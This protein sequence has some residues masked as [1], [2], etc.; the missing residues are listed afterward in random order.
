MISV[1]AS[2]KR[3]VKP[4][5]QTGRG[6]VDVRWSLVDSSPGMRVL[7][8]DGESVMCRPPAGHELRDVFADSGS[9][10]EAVARA[11][12]GNPHVLQCRMAIDQ[13]VPRGRV[14]VLAHAALDERGVGEH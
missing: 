11:A 6:M 2:V 4:R 13:E 3:L 9:V 8:G 1:A 12:A 10:L 14:L 5:N 7:R